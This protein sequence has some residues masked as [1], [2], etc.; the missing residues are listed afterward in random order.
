VSDRFEIGPVDGLDDRPHLVM[1]RPGDP[2]AT[3][4]EFVADVFG[5][6]LDDALATHGC[7]LF[8]GFGLADDQQFSQLVEALASE[9]LE[10]Q[11]RSTKRTRTAGHVYTSTEY[12]ATKTIASHSE[13]SFQTTVPGKILF[14][15]KT[16]SDTGG[17]TPIASNIEILERLD[18]EILAELRGRGIEYLRNFDGGFDLSWQE[19]FQT[20]DRA[21]VGEYCARN[22]IECEWISDDHLRTKQRRPATRRHPRTG[23]EVWFNQLHL[24]HSSNL[25]PTMRQALLDALGVDGVP[26]NAR[27]GD[28]GELGDDLVEA[29]RAAI[30][31]A[32]AVYPWRA[33][34]VLIGDNLLVSHGRRPY[35]G[36]R[37]IRVALIDPIELGAER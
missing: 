10:Y 32:E 18:A 7:L 4:E 25:E 11:E 31:A 23:A 15:A 21:V 20:D 13:N 36:H 28:G 8:R 9:Q 35:T 16:P 27:F 19:A 3:I 30:A 29:V 5:G 33:G 2:A 17:E 24:F 26:R 12:P 37:E 1:V 6:D 22:A 14:F 34:D